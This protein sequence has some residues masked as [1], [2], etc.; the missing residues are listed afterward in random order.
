MQQARQNMTFEQYLLLINN[1]D[2]N[3]LWIGLRKQPWRIGLKPLAI[4]G[5]LEDNVCWRDY[6]LI[7]EYGMFQ[8]N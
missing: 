5:P 8:I 2:P 6:Q 4:R 7:Q 1:S 3:P